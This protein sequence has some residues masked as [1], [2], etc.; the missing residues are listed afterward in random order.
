MDILHVATKKISDFESRALSVRLLLFRTHSLNYSV[1]HI[2]PYTCNKERTALEFNQKNITGSTLRN[3]S[4]Q[5]EYKTLTYN[6]INTY[7]GAR[8]VR[9]V[10]NPTPY[11]KCNSHCH[12]HTEQIQTNIST[13]NSTHITKLLINTITLYILTEG[14]WPYQPSPSER[15]SLN[16]STT[17]T[18]RAAHLEDSLLLGLGVAAAALRRRDVGTK[19]AVQMTVHS[20]VLHCKHQ[21][22][23][24]TVQSHIYF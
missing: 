16:I 14:W 7:M 13:V 18:I 4:I 11:V 17:L 2:W 6:C 22:Y 3:T 10:L 15:S 5:H 24:Y 19:R 8:N 1:Y 9:P 21:Q 20:L 23:S 12:S